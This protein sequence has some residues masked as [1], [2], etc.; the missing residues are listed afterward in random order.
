MNFALMVSTKVEEKLALV[1]RDDDW[2]Q[3]DEDKQYKK[4]LAEVLDE[5]DTNPQAGGNIRIGDYILLGKQSHLS[6]EIC[7]CFPLQS[8]PILEY[9][10]IACSM[11]LVRWNKALMSASCNIHLVCFML[12]RTSLKAE[13]RK[14]PHNHDRL[15]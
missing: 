7:S 14:L 9:P 13:S 10:R 2:S 15:N 1:E 8:T 6:P 4:A 5:M 11:L 12:P 3:Q